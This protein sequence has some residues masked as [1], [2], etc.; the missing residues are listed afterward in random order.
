MRRMLIMLE[1][2]LEFKYS[3]KDDMP[4]LKEMREIEK[5]GI[6]PLEVRVHVLAD[7]PIGYIPRNIIHND[8]EFEDLFV[9]DEITI[10]N[11]DIQRLIKVEFI[12]H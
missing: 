11:S 1:M 10:N 3:D 9:D 2:F 8:R 7:L 4:T 6:L 12:K 5:N